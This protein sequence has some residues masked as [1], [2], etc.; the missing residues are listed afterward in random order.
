MY[1]YYHR[2]NSITTNGFSEKTLD[3]I[4]GA[5][6]NLDIVEKEFPKAVPGAMFRYDWSYLWVL[7]RILLDERW[8]ENRYL[9]EILLHIHKHFLRIMNSPYFTKNR[10]IGAVVAI[11]SPAIYRKIVQYIWSRKWK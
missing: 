5:K 1:Y 3:E 11:I 4:E 2:N 10:K 8:R 7:D 9:K 6:I